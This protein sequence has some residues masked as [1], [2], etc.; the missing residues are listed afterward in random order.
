[1][2]TNLETRII[3]GLENDSSVVI[4]VPINIVIES[5]GR[6]PE[7]Y[8][9]E[10]NLRKIKPSY[11][12]IRHNS[13]KNYNLGEMVNLVLRT[14]IIPQIYLIE[15]Y[16]P[17]QIGN[18]SLSLETNNLIPGWYDLTLHIVSRDMPDLADL[19]E[20][21]VDESIY[22]PLYEV[23]LLLVHPSELVKAQH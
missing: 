7:L 2:V 3:K 8:K 16:M 12:P 11:E 4:G 19:L 1:M 23:N 6:D 14:V 5:L 15:G 20:E 10:Y 17:L 22:I 9:I 18:N 21:E 13:D